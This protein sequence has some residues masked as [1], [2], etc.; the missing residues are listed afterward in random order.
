[1]FIILAMNIFLSEKKSSRQT[2]V[3][4]A[5]EHLFKAIPN[6]ECLAVNHVMFALN[7]NMFFVTCTRLDASYG[8]RSK[9]I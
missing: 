4:F 5:R 1:M 3:Y 7:W 6:F 2:A 9:L 8:K